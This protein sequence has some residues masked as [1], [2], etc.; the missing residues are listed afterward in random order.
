[1]H[2][3]RRVQAT[4]VSKERMPIG[5]R[6]AV[7]GW[8]FVLRLVCAGYALGGLLLG[9]LF[10]L[11]PALGLPLLAASVLVALGVVLD[12]RRPLRTG[13]LLIVGAPL[14]ADELRVEAQGQRAGGIEDVRDSAAHARSEVE[15]DLSDHDDASC[16]H[17]LARVVA[18]AFDDGR[19]ARVPNGEALAGTACAEELA[20]CRAVEH[21][22]AEQD[23]ITGIVGR[24]NDDD[25]PAAH[26]LADI[27]VR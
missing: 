27:V 13:L 2:G 4:R 12:R 17:V 24:R 19:R 21:R 26:S 11:V 6:L 14:G 8:P 18:G 9:F 7:L 10:L 16:G 25:P 23:R 22:V 5:I 20:A 1:M 15:A 3:D